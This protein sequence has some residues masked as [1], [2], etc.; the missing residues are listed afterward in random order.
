MAVLCVNKTVKNLKQKKQNNHDHRTD[1]LTGN[2]EADKYN[3]QQYQENKI[4]QFEQAV[5]TTKKY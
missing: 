2:K 3:R 4:L 1:N 5:T